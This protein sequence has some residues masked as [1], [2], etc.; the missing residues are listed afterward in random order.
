[1]TDLGNKTI[2][3]ILNCHVDIDLNLVPK[4]VVF[5]QAPLHIINF[6]FIFFKIAEY[7]QRAPMSDHKFSSGFQQYTNKMN[8]FLQI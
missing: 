5:M 3:I 4:D 2:V 1:M 7:S 8:R 6:F